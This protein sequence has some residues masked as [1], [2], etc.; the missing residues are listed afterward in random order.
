[1]VLCSKV[2]CI[3]D[4]CCVPQSG[5]DW[6]VLSAGQNFTQEDVDLNRLAYAPPAPPGVRGHDPAPPGVRGQDSFSF[7]L[8]DGQN[9]SPSQSFSI[10]MPGSTPG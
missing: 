4:P 8:S 5:P 3:P 6:S 10:S 7:H 9:D 2:L 1:M